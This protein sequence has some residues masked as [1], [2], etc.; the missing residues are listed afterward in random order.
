MLN[1]LQP[2]MFNKNKDIKMIPFATSVDPV[3][4]KAGAMLDKTVVSR[5]SDFSFV[6]Y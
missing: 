1:Q 6:I 4:G 3:V 5:L 2:L